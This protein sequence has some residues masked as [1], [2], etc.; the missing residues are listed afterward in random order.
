VTPSVTVVTPVHNCMPY[1]EDTLASVYHQSVDRAEVEMVVVDDGS[2]DGSAECL[3]RWVQRW[4][5]LTVI[6]QQ[7]SGSA[8]RPRNVGIE[9]ARGEYLFF[10][11]GDDCL[12]PLALER[13]LAMARRNDSDVV[14]A[15]IVGV[16]RKAPGALFR[17]D[18]D[19]ADFSAGI[20]WSL[21]PFKLVRRS[22]VVEHQL[23]FPEHMR[24]S[25]DQLFVAGCYFAAKRIS[26]LGSYDC[27]YLV[28]RRDG[29]N[30]S[31]EGLDYPT[32]LSQAAENVAL[33]RSQTGPGEV[34]D[35][36]LARH[37]K[38][39][40]LRRINSRFL[41][42]HAHAQR[43]MV[44]LA[45]PYALDWGSPS[46]LASFRVPDRLQLIAV[47]RGAVDEL[48]ALVEWVDAGAPARTRRVGDGWVVEAPYSSAGI[49]PAEAFRTYDDPQPVA[50]VDDVSCDGHR[51]R[52]VG[53]ALLRGVDSG[54]AK[55]SVLARH[56]RT[57]VVREA[58]LTDRPTP[59]LNALEGH[60][61]VGHTDAGFVAD[62]DLAGARPGRWDVVVRLSAGDYETQ[63][64][65]RAPAGVE[66]APEVATRAV[67]GPSGNLLIEVPKP[68]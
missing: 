54:D 42:A 31:F 2:T 35:R 8:S 64:R 65:L 32:I 38:V 61:V 53:H 28:R 23:R 39:E 58:V 18:L 50:G 19:H 13:L 60:G 46:V 24:V 17:K 33:V 10:L 12:G 30:T 20:Y 48:R 1:L 52:V 37:L 4:P 22:L 11:D 6:T 44:E 3:Q 5:Q 25:E 55:V 57:G 34:R 15:K 21:V 68:G 29:S 43:E 63:T 36:C 7:A 56:R 66:E 67:A 41:A 49:F 14:L 16:N 27:Y 51:V 9:H 26:V 40:L 45:R 59:Y 62:L 47:Q